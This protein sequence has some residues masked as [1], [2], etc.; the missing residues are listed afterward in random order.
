MNKKKTREARTTCKTEV[1]SKN[2]LGPTDITR[3]ITG[4]DVDDT[5]FEGNKKKVE[6]TIKKIKKSSDI[7]N[8][9][10]IKEEN[11]NE[12]SK[13][14]KNI[15]ENQE[16][17]NINNKISSDKATIE[18]YD[19]MIEMLLDVI[20]E[21]EDSNEEKIF[22]NKLRDE[23][24]DSKEIE[25]VKGIKDEIS[26]LYNNIVDINSIMSKENKISY[27]NDIKNKICNINNYLSFNIQMYTTLQERINSVK[28]K[29]PNIKNM[30]KIDINDFET[31]GVN[32]IAEVVGLPTV[33]EME[34]LIDKA[35]KNG[36]RVIVE[37]FELIYPLMNK[38][39]DLLI[40]V[41]G[42]I[43]V[44][45]P[46]IFGPEPEDI[47]KRVFHSINIRKMAHSAEDLVEFF[48]P[49][50]IRSTCEHGDVLNGFILLF[51]S[52]P[53]IDIKDI[54]SKVNKI[55]EDDIPIQYYDE[56]HVKIGEYIH[57]CSGP[58]IHVSSTSK[59]ENFKLLPK[60]YYDSTKKVYMLVGLV[61]DSIDESYKDLNKI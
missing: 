23:I 44:T 48:L 20:N 61:G 29:Y 2:L 11:F 39:A 33:E 16:L 57:P 53:D 3:K 34:N 55:I 30:D 50:E 41:G 19:V 25:I 58:R 40:G 7:S 52:K 4:L 49:E 13:V 51:H 22:I 43:I 47:A 8:G 28:D 36:K 37:H 12:F 10:S 60:F 42:E 45:R 18:D 9:T 31:L 6:R 38:N 5:L 46:T 59:I 21:R 1:K 17:D 26:K 32:F 35:I 54:E 56:K 14:I 24:K 15:I 27:F